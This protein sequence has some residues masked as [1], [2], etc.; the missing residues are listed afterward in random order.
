MVSAVNNLTFDLEMGSEMEGGMVYQDEDGNLIMYNHD[1]MGE[2]DDDM[3]G[4]YGMEGS[5]GVSFIH[6]SYNCL[7]RIKKSTSMRTQPFRTCPHWIRCVSSA[8]TSSSP[9]M[10]TVA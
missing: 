7:F 3:G 4:E 5:P 10:T 1:E 9:S 6:A 2:D 8:E